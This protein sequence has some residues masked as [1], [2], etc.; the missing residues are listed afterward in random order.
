MFP[1][2][3]RCQNEWVEKS[4]LLHQGLNDVE[5]PT[6]GRR[7]VEERLTHGQGLKPV[8]MLFP[9]NPW[10]KHWTSVCAGCQ[11]R[12]SSF[13]FSIGLADQYSI[14]LYTVG[15]RKETREKNQQFCVFMLFYFFL[16]VFVLFIYRDNLGLSVPTLRKRLCCLNEAL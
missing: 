7:S 8:Q 3:Q 4:V 9:V 2:M 5:T 14:A 12:T 13:P 10:A 16:C 11:T 15:P 1:M 6:V